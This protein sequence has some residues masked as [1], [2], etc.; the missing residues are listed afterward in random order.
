MKSYKWQLAKS[1]I[2]VVTIAAMQIQTIR[3][4]TSI[5]HMTKTNKKVSML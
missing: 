1:S 3:K 5:T 4:D 2:R